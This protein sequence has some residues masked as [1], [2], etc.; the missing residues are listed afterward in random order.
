M[1]YDTFEN[2]DLYSAHGSILY[3]A[4]C[5]ARDF[6]PKSAVGIYTFEGDEVFARVVSY[7]TTVAQTNA[8][9]AHQNYIDVQVL[10][11]GYEQIDVALA[12][13]G[14]LVTLKPYDSTS[15]MAIYQSPE[16]FISLHMVPGRFAVLFPD[17]VHRPNCA[18]DS[19]SEVK[20]ICVKLRYR[21]QADYGRKLH[22]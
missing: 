13:Q 6:D 3:R 5:Y 22:E 2:I 18:W 15:D 12:S 10:L 16:D 4:I 8:F 20:K 21:T 11:S 7:T 1:I 17:D 14:N 9:E 19:P